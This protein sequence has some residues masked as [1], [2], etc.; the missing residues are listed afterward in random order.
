MRVDRYRDTQGDI[1]VFLGDGTGALSPGESLSAGE[2]PTGI[3][4][5]DL[6]N[7]GLADLVVASGAGVTLLVA[8]GGPD[9]T[10]W[11]SP[12]LEAGSQPREV[13]VA[14]FAAE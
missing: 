3:T 13:A 4:V 11:Q 7:N 12:E 8:E 6:K 5:T 1:E 9:P 10:F 14:D 2:L